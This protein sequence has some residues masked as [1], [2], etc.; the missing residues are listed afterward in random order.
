LLAGAGVS[1]AVPAALDG[2]AGCGAG[3]SCAGRFAAPEETT[4]GWFVAK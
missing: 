4:L 3:T 2:A 1:G